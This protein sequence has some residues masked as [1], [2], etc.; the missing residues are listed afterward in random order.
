MHTLPRIPAGG[1]SHLSLFPPPMVTAK[2][3]F[4]SCPS[5]RGHVRG[6][7]SVFTT[8]MTPRSKRGV[9][10]LEA[11]IINGLP[12][13]LHSFPLS[14]FL[15]LA[16]WSCAG[17]LSPCINTFHFHSRSTTG[18][19]WLRPDHSAVQRVPLLSRGLLFLEMGPSFL[20]KTT[21]TELNHQGSSPRQTS[22]VLLESFRPD[23]LH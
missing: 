11:P 18:P 19:R 5:A 14:C 21:A 12:P 10:Q 17:R 22:G 9:C 16:I 1:F 8:S 4:F 15:F 23:L 7:T 6:V 20:R 2:G 13:P 3:L